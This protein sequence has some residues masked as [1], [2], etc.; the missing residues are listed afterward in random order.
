M[1]WNLV[2]IAK[3]YIMFFAMSVVGCVPTG[4][5]TA[6][7]INRSPAFPGDAIKEK[8][9]IFWITVGII[10]KNTQKSWESHGN[11][12]TEPTEDYK[13]SRMPLCHKLNFAGSPLQLTYG[14]Y[15]TKK[16]SPDLII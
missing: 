8:M 13:A 10:L 11:I 6:I 12:G 1:K 15:A 5:V 4:L 16:K 14:C 7:R 2:L 9:S 3:L